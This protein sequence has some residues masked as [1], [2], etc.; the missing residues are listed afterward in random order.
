VETGRLTLE[1][2]AE[3]VVLLVREAAAASAAAA[4]IRGIVLTASCTDALPSLHCD[5][6]RLLQVLGNLLGNALSVTPATGAVSIRAEREADAI[7]FSVSDTGPG[8]ASAALPHLF[9]RHFR[10]GAEY[11]GTGL[12][13]SIAHGIVV[14]HGGRLW[15]ESEAGAG[16]TFHFS[17]PLTPPV[18]EGATR[19]V[20]R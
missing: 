2:G 13:L 7:V 14:A 4:A 3:G 11:V 6:E 20:P 18:E 8:I 9:E 1:R 12:G 10:G 16:A 15:A 17:I 19:T 5:R